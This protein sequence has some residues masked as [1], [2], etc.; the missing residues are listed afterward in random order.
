MSVC[1]RVRVCV[2]VFASVAVRFIRFVF[3]FIVFFV[4][5]AQFAAAVND[6]DDALNN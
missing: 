6:A 2:G 5:H 1:V 3:V 4:I